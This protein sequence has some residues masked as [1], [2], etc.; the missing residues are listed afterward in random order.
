MPEKL[1]EYLDVYEGVKSEIYTTKFDGNS[2]VGA[3]YL[4]KENMTRSEK[5][6]VED[7]FPI[8]E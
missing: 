4:G 7:K 1:K 3:T 2:H 8:S 5:I 6:K